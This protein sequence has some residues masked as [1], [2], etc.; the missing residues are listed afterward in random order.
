MKVLGDPGP[1]FP[2]DTGGGETVIS[3]DMI[4][5]AKVATLGLREQAFIGVE[6]RGGRRFLGHKSRG[7]SRGQCLK[8]L[9]FPCRPLH[10]RIPRYHYNIL[11]PLVTGK[12]TVLSC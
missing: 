6:E 5:T 9:S 11:S 8:A 4:V 3:N 1:A 12:T 2:E 10:R 7:K